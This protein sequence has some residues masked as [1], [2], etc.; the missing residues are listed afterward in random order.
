MRGCVHEGD[1]RDPVNSPHNPTGK[2]FT[3][4][5]L[6]FL[7]ELCREHDVLCITDEVYEHLV[8]EGAHVPM[9]TLPG[10]RERTITISSFGKTFSLTGWKIGWAVGT[11]RARAARCAPRISSSPSRRRRRCSTARAV[12]LAQAGEAYYRELLADYRA[13][14]DF[15]VRELSRIGFSVAARRARTSSAPTFGPSASTTIR[16]SSAT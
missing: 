5:E 16:R 12:A 11:A 4:D 14:R 3:P 6:A 15:L 2:V 8:Y 1:A 10:M 7:A 13:R 9:A